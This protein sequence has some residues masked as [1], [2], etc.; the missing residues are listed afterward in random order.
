MSK[1]TW[2]KTYDEVLEAMQLDKSFFDKEENDV[3]EVFYTAP[4]LSR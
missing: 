3:I 4:S 1:E 2:K